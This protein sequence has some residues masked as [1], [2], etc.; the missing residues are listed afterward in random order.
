MSADTVYMRLAALAAPAGAALLS[1]V[2]NLEWLGLGVCVG[3]KE[4]L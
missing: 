1:V 3:V 2:V 4:F